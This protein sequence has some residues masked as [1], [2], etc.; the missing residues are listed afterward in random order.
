MISSL[1]CSIENIE[2]LEKLKPF[3]Q[4]FEAPVFDVGQLHVQG[5]QILKNQYPKWQLAHPLCALE[6][7]SFSLS[8]DVVEKKLEILTGTLSV[9]QYMSN[10]KAQILVNSFKEYENS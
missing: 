10:K 1:E 4:G 8:K 5:V 3:G 6:A 9:N 2:E 7:I